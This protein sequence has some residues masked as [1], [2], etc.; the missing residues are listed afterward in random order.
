MAEQSHYGIIK[1]M[2]EKLQ[3]TVFSVYKRINIFIYFL[4]VILRQK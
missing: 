2:F 3:N 4:V 1:N